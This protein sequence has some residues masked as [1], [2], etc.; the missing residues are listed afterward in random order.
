[1]ASKNETDDYEN[2]L[3]YKIQKCK[4]KITENDRILL[5]LNDQIS[6]YKRVLDKLEPFDLETF[7]KH[8][9]NFLKEI[10]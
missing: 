6:M 3:Q 8:N 4:E 1:M 10:N 2:K 5:I 9:D 7:N